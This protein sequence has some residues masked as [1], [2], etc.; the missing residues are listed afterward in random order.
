M[1][2]YVICGGEAGKARLRII[3]H[4]LWPATLDLLHRAGIKSGMACL[5]VG[6]GGGDVTLEMARLI[7]PSGMVT[8]IDMDSTKMQLAQQE[9]EHDRITNAQFLARDIAH[10]DHEAAYDLVYARLFL[11]HLRD[12]LDA[13]QRMV[14]ATKP[15]GVVIVE[16]MDHAGI[17]CYPACPALEQHVSLYNQLVRLQGADPE[18]G[19]KLPALFRQVGLQDLHLSHVQPAFMA[20]DAKRIHQI[21]LENIAPAVIAAGLASEAETNAL[22]TELDTFAQNSQ[23][24]VS[25]PRMF[26]VWASRK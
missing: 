20:G 22:I 11:T 26:Q 21:T 15:G 17:F 19:P 1:T 16:D 10:L 13:L 2:G 3:A 25:F 18:I 7:G 9:A 23:T 6:C 8:G 12:P 24:I 14:Q 4:A 5:D